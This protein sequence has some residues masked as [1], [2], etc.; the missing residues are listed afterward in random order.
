MNKFLE[1]IIRE[2]IKTV[3]KVEYA[4]AYGS[5]VSPQKGY[6]YKNKKL[7]MVDL[8]FAVNDIEEWHNL[9]LKMNKNVF[10]HFFNFY[11]IIVD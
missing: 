5:A 1:P 11:S 10:Y 9:N 4:F 7:P 6:D 2:F 8:I 3:P